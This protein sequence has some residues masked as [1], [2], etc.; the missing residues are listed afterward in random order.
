MTCPNQ[1]AVRTTLD[2]VAF[3]DFVVQTVSR[4]HFGHGCPPLY[5]RGDTVRGPL[6]DLLLPAHFADRG[7]AEVQ[8]PV[9]GPD[10]D[11][12]TAS[13]APAFVER[14][15]RRRGSLALWRSDVAPCFPGQ[16]DPPDVRVLAEP[17]RHVDRLCPDVAQLL[18][19]R[20]A[21]R[22]TVPRADQAAKLSPQPSAST[23]TTTSVTPQTG[24]VPYAPPRRAT[25]PETP[26]GYELSRS[27]ARVAWI[28]AAV[29]A[30]EPS[31][32]CA[33]ESSRALPRICRGI[34]GSGT[35]R[36]LFAIRE[37]LRAAAA[38][39]RR[40]D[41]ADALQLGGSV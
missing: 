23:A 32:A 29:Q 25:A 37:P 30:R 27:A 24:S 20:F 1:Q 16:L 33:D 13:L 14:R 31:S 6:P 17:A 38:S 36:R 7:A 3:S 35:T 11:L 10:D 19:S 40:P 15:P 39:G 4:D 26:T 41:P 9:L 2:T 12:A 28:R 22:C 8:L 21:H 34:V 5:R 18:V